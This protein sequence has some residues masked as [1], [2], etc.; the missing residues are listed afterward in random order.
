MDKHYSTLVAT[1]VVCQKYVFI[2]GIYFSERFFQNQ[3][4]VD[5]SDVWNICIQK[6]GPESLVA[7]LEF[8]LMEDYISPVLVEQAMAYMSILAEILKSR[9][10]R[11]KN[12]A[13]TILMKFFK[14]LPYQGPLFYNVGQQPGLYDSIVSD[15][16]S[17]IWN[18]SSSDASALLEFEKLFL[19]LV[20]HQ[21]SLCRAVGM[22]IWSFIVKNSTSSLQERYIDVVVELVMNGRNSSQMQLQ[23]NLQNF[24]VVPEEVL[25]PVFRRFIPLLDFQRQEKLYTALQSR[26]QIYSDHARLIK[27]LPAEIPGI[28][29]IWQ[30]TYNTCVQTALTKVKETSNFKYSFVDLVSSSPRKKSRKLM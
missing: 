18:I 12:S 4:P 7:A 30:P 23:R 28:H 17:L 13:I 6:H 5:F 10:I 21:V 16:I 26:A 8:D 3:I 29:N 9:A 2:C 11:E 20:F 14:L 24:P 19:P 27:I 1:L 25:L 15:V 22:D